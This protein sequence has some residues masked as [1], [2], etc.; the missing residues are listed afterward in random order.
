MT[1]SDSMSRGGWPAFRV[2]ILDRY[3]LSEL[4]G[5]FVFGLSSWLLPDNVS[6]IVDLITGALFLGSLYAGLRRP[7]FE[8]PQPS[9]QAQN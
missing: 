6:N 5:P 4:A 7:R 9:Q 3:M 8:T 1:R 2:P